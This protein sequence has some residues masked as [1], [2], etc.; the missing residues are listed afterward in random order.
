MGRKST[1]TSEPGHGLHFHPCERIS[2][3]R[4]LFSRDSIL[5]PT[6]S[7]APSGRRVSNDRSLP[8]S[9]PSSISAVP[10]AS[11]RNAHSQTIATR[12]PASSRL[13]RLCRSRSTLESNFACQNSGRV[14]G[15]VAYGQ[16]VWR[17]QKQPWT[18]HTA[19]NRRNTRSGVPGSLRSCRR[20][21]RPR[22][23]RARR[24]TSS[25]R[26]FLLPIPAI[27]RERV[28]LS[29]MSVICQAFATDEA[30]RRRLISPKF[31]GMLKHGCTPDQDPGRDM[32]L[33]A[34]HQS[35]RSRVREQAT[36]AEAPF[37]CRSDDSDSGLRAGSP[38]GSTP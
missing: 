10:T 6:G 34:R 24:R 21:L 2:S 18:R 7:Y 30:Y 20:Y 22:A 23:W 37:R 14:A 19:R 16:S 38:V 33:G 35:V 12:Q 15:V 31:P 3:C 4:R 17:C 5:F 25:G 13:R 1:L 36:R 9:H 28:V 32:S 26:V 29:T 8:R 11:L 27:I